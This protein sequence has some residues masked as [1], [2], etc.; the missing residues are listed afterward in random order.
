M[1]S[2]IQVLLWSKQYGFQGAIAT[3]CMLT[4]EIAC[5]DHPM[6]SPAVVSADYD[7]AVFETLQKF[8]R[9]HVLA[10]GEQHWN[11]EQHDFLK[12]LITHR[13]FTAHV[14]HIVVEFGNA[15]YQAELNQYLNLESDDSTVIRKALTTGSQVT[16]WDGVVY[17]NFFRNVR[18]RN[19]DLAEGER[20]I[21]FLGEPPIDWSTIHNG[22]EFMTWYERNGRTAFMD[23]LNKMIV[24][25]G[26]PMLWIAGTGHVRR[27]GDNAPTE[28][29][30]YR[31]GIYNRETQPPLHALLPK[32]RA[33][34]I[35]FLN[36][37]SILALS[38]EDGRLADGFDGYYYLKPY[39]Q[40]TTCGK[41]P[42]LYRDEQLRA[43]IQ[44]RWNILRD[45]GV[46]NGAISSSYFNE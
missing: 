2:F 44:R 21:I 32:K 10:M 23:S 36:D 42:G 37:S 45:A 31:T 19:A 14:R 17:E 24:S 29:G 18:R 7:S 34:L 41:M 30:T 5:T 8:K 39:Q 6:E 33:R 11:V 46:V 12:A 4:A 13:D 3:L 27:R 28:R 9:H 40:L 15:L 43:E 25:M 35:D 20:I 22:E 1:K 38:T 26:N 16:A